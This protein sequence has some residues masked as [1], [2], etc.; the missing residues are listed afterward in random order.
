V[1]EKPTVQWPTTEYA[2]G[3]I[4]LLTLLCLFPLFVAAGVWVGHL[5]HQKLALNHPVVR[6]AQQVQDQQAGSMEET[7]DEVKAFYS[8]GQTLEV[9]YKTADEKQE[10]FA[11][12]SGL[13]GGFMGL[14]IGGTLLIHSVFWKRSEYEAQRAGCVAC[15]RCYNYC[16]RHRKWLS[17]KN[18]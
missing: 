11:F 16:P 9:L 7:T 12:G 17:E 18:G 6:L 5:A 13:A 3:R 2:R 1:I 4:R 14:V 8:S 10:Q 15:G